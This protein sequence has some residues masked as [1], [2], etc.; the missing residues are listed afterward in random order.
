MWPRR[1]RFFSH[2][3]GDTLFRRAFGLL[4]GQHAAP[5]EFT[6]VERDKQTEPGFDGSCLFVQFVAVE[7]V[8]NFRPQGV[9]CTEPGGLEATGPA[10]RQEFG[11]DGLDDFPRRDDLEA[12]FPGVAR[13]AQIHGLS[14]KLREG[15]FVLFQLAG[16]RD[17]RAAGEGSRETLI[18]ELANPGP[19]K[20]HGAGLVRDI[21]EPDLGAARR[22]GVLFFQPGHVGLDARG[23]D[24]HQKILF[25]DAVGVEV[26]DDAA[27]F[28]AQQ[29]VLA[30]PDGQLARVIGQRVVEEL[31]RGGT[32]D[33]DFAHMADVEETACPAHRQM[34][35]RDA[36]VVDGHFPAA[37]FDEFA[38]Q[39]LVGVEERCALQHKPGSGQPNSFGPAVN[40][41]GGFM[42][43]ACV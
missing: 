7:R 13:A 29:G 22:G 15:N 40:A 36:G 9:A 38:A 28:M 3:E 34:L 25:P 32:A 19:L 1:W 10:D 37:E 20:S 12:I 35:L 17:F 43:R 42:A 6:L 8:T 14:L 27:S 4:P 21:P 31:E 5:D 30:L 33:G 2:L 41:P 11:P 23:V 18:H 26:V 16:V 39:P 24:D